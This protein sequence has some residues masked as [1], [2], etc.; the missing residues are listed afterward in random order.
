MQIAIISDIHGNI[1]AL[2]QEQADI[3]N[4][5]VEKIIELGDNIG[6]VP[7]SEQVVARILDRGI[8]SILGNHELALVEPEILDWFN[9]AARESLLKTQKM[10]SKQ[11]LAFIESMKK[12]MVMYGCRF[13]HGFPPDSVMTYMFEVD[14][15]GLERAFSTSKDQLCFTG[16]THRLEAAGSD[17]EKIRRHRLR[18]GIFQI[19]PSHKY[20]FNVGSVGQPRDGDNRAKYV[21]YDDADQTLEARFVPYDI[22]ITAKK[23]IAAGLP[24][25]HADRLW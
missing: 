18:R 21:I 14:Q 24:R 20:I 9:P 17:G 23:I 2:D 16:H 25:M 3:D 19:N 1:E 12:S 13:V 7:D 6:Y 11:S 22:V 5:Q 10:L 15:G 4:L 8:P